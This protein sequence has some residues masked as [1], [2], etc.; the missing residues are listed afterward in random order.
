VIQ[1]DNAWRRV[2]FAQAVWRCDDIVHQAYLYNG[3][4]FNWNYGIHIDEDLHQFQEAQEA[5]FAC[6]ECRVD[7]WYHLHI[8]VDTY[9]MNATPRLLLGVVFESKQEIWWG[10][11]M[12]VSIAFL[13][14]TKRFV[15]YAFILDGCQG[16]WCVGKIDTDQSI[17]K[18]KACG[19]CLGAFQLATRERPSD[20]TLF[21]SDL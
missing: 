6:V 3:D 10:G 21:E 5:F 16:I 8:Y 18:G 13:Q 7:E 14:I 15:S 19:A 11:R 1:V 20:V 4:S 12:H 2:L 9:V 17:G